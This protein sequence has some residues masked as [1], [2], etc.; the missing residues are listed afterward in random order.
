MVALFAVRRPLGVELGSS[1]IRVC[2]LG[3]GRV[4]VAPARGIRHGRILDADACARTVRRQLAGPGARGRAGEVVVAVPAVDPAG[5]ERA[6]AVLRAAGASGVSTVDQPLVAA[7]GAGL[8][9]ADRP[10]ELV[11]DIG[12]G[13]VEVAAVG[14]GA[15]R[16]QRVLEWGTEALYERLAARLAD[17]DGLYVSPGEAARSLVSG[18]VAGTDVAAWAPKT[19]TL[20]RSRLDALYAPGLAEIAGAVRETLDQLPARVAADVAAGGAVLV[21]GGSALFGLPHRLGA[22]LHLP[23]RRPDDPANAVLNGLAHLLPRTRATA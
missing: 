22:A 23:V 6:A 4:R 21:G 9:V 20:T 10:G 16:A 18:H 11:V 14:D 12:A 7:I 2:R 3:G 8:D 17:G 13:L 19:L 5:H 1:A 15:V